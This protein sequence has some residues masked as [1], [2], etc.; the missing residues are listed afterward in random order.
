MAFDERQRTTTN[1]SFGCVFSS[2][3]GA[4]AILRAQRRDAAMQSMRDI[5][6]RMAVSRRPRTPANKQTIGTV[7]RRLIA[8]ECGTDSTQTNRFG[9]ADTSND[10]LNGHYI[11]PGR[12]RV[13]RKVS[14]CGSHAIVMSSARNAPSYMFVCCVSLSV[15]TQ[16][17]CQPVFVCLFPYWSLLLLCV[18]FLLSY[19]LPDF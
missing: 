18:F 13:R 7:N 16:I 9:P 12:R 15:S 5:E 8:P 6:S 1:L 4:H 2:K 11:R 10:R 17:P 3:F 14:Q 19:C